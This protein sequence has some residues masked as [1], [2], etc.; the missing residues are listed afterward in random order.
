[1]HIYE[2]DGKEYPSVTTIIQSL[3]SEEIVKWAN[4]LGF[5]HLDYTKEL[6]KTA[7]NGT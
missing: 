7:V 4:H 5:K 3:G 6:E 2:K 1:M